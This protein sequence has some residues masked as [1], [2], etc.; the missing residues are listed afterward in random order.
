LGRFN[1]R[2]FMKLS[3]A[4]AIGASLAVDAAALPTT[5]GPKGNI[6]IWQ[7]AG[8]A[9]HTA[10]AATKWSAQSKQSATVIEIDPSR[11]FQS[12][13]GFGAA[14]TDAACFTINRLNPDARKQ[15]LHDFFHPSELGLNVSRLCIGSSDYATKQYS[16]SEGAEPDPDL[17]RFSI[18]HDRAYILPILR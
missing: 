1:R 2:E 12:V 8:S 13:L 18:D 5:E 15:L 11:E 4:G 7:T 10:Q 6:A 16:Y 17:K 14:L 9:R 3:A